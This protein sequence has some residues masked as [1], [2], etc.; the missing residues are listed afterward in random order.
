MK[1]RRKKKAKK[2]N[3][4][5]KHRNQRNKKKKKD[6]KSRIDTLRTI[7]YIYLSPTANAFLIFHF[8]KFLI[9]FFVLLFMALAPKLKNDSFKYLTFNK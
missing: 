8:Y 3:K 9:S 1:H 4:K 6:K 5:M 7:I 2:K